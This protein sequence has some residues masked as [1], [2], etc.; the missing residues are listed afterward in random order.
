[1]LAV[2]E[3]IGDIEGMMKRV[4]DTYDN[5]IKQKLKQILALFEPVVMLTLGA[6][7]AFIVVSMF[8]HFQKSQALNKGKLDL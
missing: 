1:M 5:D 2:G 3:E 4:A 8:H 6:A 7:V